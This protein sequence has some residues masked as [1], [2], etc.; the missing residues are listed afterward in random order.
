METSKIPV[1]EDVLEKIKAYCLEAG[2]PVENWVATT[3]RFLEKNDID[4]YNETCEPTLAGSSD[5]K[6]ERAQLIQ[7]CELMSEFLR[8]QKQR[9]AHLPDPEALQKA[10]ADIAKLKEHI[11]EY[12]QQLDEYHKKHVAFVY[13]IMKWQNKYNDRDKQYHC[14]LFDLNEKMRL[15][16]KAKAEL[17]RCKGLFA[18]ANEEVLKELGI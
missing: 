18:T 4:I 3:W 6:E 12:K 8:K 9:Q 10:E 16:E 17:K 1:P 14:T 2:Q 7:L 11:K 15:P 5:V 13:E